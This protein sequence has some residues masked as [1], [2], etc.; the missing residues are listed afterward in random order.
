MW[1]SPCDCREIVFPWWNKLEDAW[2]FLVD[3]SLRRKIFIYSNST[4]SRP[5]CTSM[6][7]HVLFNSEKIANISNV[8][9]IPLHDLIPTRNGLQDIMKYTSQHLASPLECFFP[10]HLRAISE[11][12][13]YMCTR[14]PAITTSSSFSIFKLHSSF[15]E[16][17]FIENFFFLFV[18]MYRRV[19]YIGAQTMLS[20]MSLIVKSARHHERWSCATIAQA[21]CFSSLGDVN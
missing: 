13:I 19:A 11:L 3:K 12:S 7:Q 1:T 21:V 16:N 5:P 17:V 14:T 15:E 10:Q 18:Y 4:P 6:Q 2:M 8:A 20:C 9:E